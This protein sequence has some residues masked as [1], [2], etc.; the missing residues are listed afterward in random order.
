MKKSKLI[1]LLGALLIS[2]CGSN[3]NSSSSI[4]NNN[5]SSNTSAST[6]SSSSKPSSS[7]SSTIDTSE[8][9]NKGNEE[10]AINNPNE[11]VYSVDENLKTTLAMEFEGE[12]YFYY[13]K[14]NNASWDSAQ[15]FYHDSE[16]GVGRGYIISFSVS[17]STAGKITINNQ[18]VE[19]TSGLSEVSIECV[20]EEDKPTISMQ[21]GTEENGII[22]E[23]LEFVF[24]NFVIKKQANAKDI[25]ESAIEA[26][27]Y[28]ITLTQGLN[29]YKVTSKFFENAALF[30]WKNTIDDVGENYGYAENATGAF[31]FSV[32]DGKIRSNSNYFKDADGEIVKGLYT[33]SYQ[34]TYDG[35][36]GLPSLYKLD[37]SKFDY[38]LKTGVKV[39]IEDGSSLKALTFMLDEFHSS[40][41]FGG[42]KETN[43]TLKENGNLEF[44]I[45][46]KMGDISK[47]ELSNIGTTEDALIEEFIASKNFCPASDVSTEGDPEVELM[48]AD[49]KGA[50]YQVNKGDAGEFYINEK[51]SYNVSIDSETNASTINGYI[52]LNDGVYSYVVEDE[53]VILGENYTEL[54]GNITNVKDLAGLDSG[55]VTYFNDASKYSKN[56]S[57]GYYEMIPT[58]SGYYTFSSKWFGISALGCE[59][60]T[61]ERGE[62]NI[63][64]GASLITA[65][66][67]GN[68]QEAMMSY[69]VVYNIGNAK[70]Q[71]M[72]D[73]LASL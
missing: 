39:T 5:V 29:G 6:S 71:F 23:N 24:T 31:G 42:I 25:I 36:E 54:Y 70:V 7:S 18:I 55:M 63:T 68:P 26:N 14:V 17:S 13:E 51:Y 44:A 34:F 61:L 56:E 10:T 62:N 64:I 15:L 52:K 30:D 45:K 49:I 3:G 2:G 32:K 46:T 72:E 4:L 43:L 21:F 11:W 37:L 38:D 59:L 67:N 57:E 20:Q 73:Y 41:Y 48:L 40:Y 66:G 1:C 50:N 12:I 8:W 65:D 58:S 60:I 16:I 35:L 69:L 27:N 47:F 33:S 28:T 19:V 9:F 22:A 53:K